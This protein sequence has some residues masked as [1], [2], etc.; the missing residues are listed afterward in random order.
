MKKLY[1]TLLTLYF[2]ITSYAQTSTYKLDLKTFSNIYLNN[3][4]TVEDEKKI[5][6][7]EMF[8]LTFQTKNKISMTYIDWTAGMY[9][10][11]ANYKTYFDKNVVEIL[12]SNWKTEKGDTTKKTLTYFY[13]YVINKDKIAILFKETKQPITETL[14]K[15]QDWLELIKVKK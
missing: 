12:T 1:I 10:L 9:N 2:S 14:F 15:D 11:T 7:E 4:W 3:G 5:K 6:T 8:L 13:F